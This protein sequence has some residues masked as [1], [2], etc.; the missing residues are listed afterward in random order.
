MI[1]MLLNGRSTATKC[2]VIM[3]LLVEVDPLPANGGIE[4]AIYDAIQLNGFWIP[5][6]HSVEVTDRP[7]EDMDGNWAIPSPPFNIA[8][9]SA[10]DGT[11]LFK[12][13]I[14]FEF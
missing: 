9:A 6:S 8:I 3:D 13:T 7:I 10:Y 12:G 4:E 5:D 1:K 2:Q 11:T 14:T